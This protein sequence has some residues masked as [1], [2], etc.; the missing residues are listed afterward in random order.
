MRQ[1]KILKGGSTEL[2]QNWN[3]E[4]IFGK[5]LELFC[6]ENTNYI[7]EDEYDRTK[8]VP[9]LVIRYNRIVAA[10]KAF[11][12]YNEKNP[13]SSFI[14]GKFI[15]QLD[16]DTAN[17]ILKSAYGKIVRYAPQHEEKILHAIARGMYKHRYNG[18]AKTLQELFCD[19]LQY[20]LS[21]E[22]LR[23]SK[24][25]GIIES[26][27]GHYIGTLYLLEFSDK[28]LLPI[29]ERLDELI[30]PIMCREEFCISEQELVSKFGYPNVTDIE[31][32]EM[33]ANYQINQKQ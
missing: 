33:T 3:T 20:R 31:L 28:E 9:H 5:I 11:K 26:D 7:A 8:D 32:M 17:E 25:T 18:L 13:I 22:K 2:N 21:V 4:I 24:G 6:F 1:V 30:L 15:E 12:L 23:R 29:I 27:G 16:E 14:E 19:L 10:L